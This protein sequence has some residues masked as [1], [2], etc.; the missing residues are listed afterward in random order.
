MLA[1]RPPGGWLGRF[2]WTHPEWWSLVL[3]ALAWGA[4]LAHAGG[5]QEQMRDTMPVPHMMPVQG[6]FLD[7]GLMV[8]AMM[9]PLI[10][11]P[12]RWVAFQSFRRRRHRAIL[13][14]LIGFLLPWM[15]LG[16][17]AA[18]L[19]TLAWSQ[20]PLLASGIFG[21]A[22]LWALAPI[23]ARA[24]VFCHR[25]IPLAPAGWPA[26]RACLRFSVMIGASCVATCGL[27]MLACAVTGHNLVAMLGGTLL[28][29]LEFRSFR[30]PTRH[31]FAGALMLAV[32]FLLPIR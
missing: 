22:A 4:V 27:L 11:A 26:D 24:L 14:F 13:L 1:I 21:L 8:V 20:T 6:E 5:G 19:R 16:I 18:W 25:T 2:F 30:P 9:A 7:W 29:A 32:W 12:L 28:G 15:L 10:L 17:V 3:V 23:R 31:I